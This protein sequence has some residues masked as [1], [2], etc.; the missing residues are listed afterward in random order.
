MGWTGARET[1]RRNFAEVSLIFSLPCN[2]LDRTH[3]NALLHIPL[4]F[5]LDDI[6]KNHDR[7]ARLI[8]LKHERAN[9]FA[10]TAS[11]ALFTIDDWLHRNTPIFN[12]IFF[13]VPRSPAALRAQGLCAT[14][15]QPSR[16]DPGQDLPLPPQES[17]PALKPGH[18]SAMPC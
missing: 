18:P 4:L 3:L 12:R 15:G 8:H 14:H 11:D 6:A 16:I 2:R 1:K 9:R 10:R 7:L 5:A 13:R 17:T